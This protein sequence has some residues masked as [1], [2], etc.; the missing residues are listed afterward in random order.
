MMNVNE[1]C[2]CERKLL[3]RKKVA[4]VN[5]NCRTDVYEIDLRR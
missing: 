3:M 4:D 2:Q 1:N 5:E